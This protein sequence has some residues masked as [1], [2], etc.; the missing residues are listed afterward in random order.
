MR[1][2]A[3]GMERMA[4]ALVLLAACNGD[5]SISLTRHDQL[6]K[7]C[8]PGDRQAWTLWIESDQCQDFSGRWESFSELWV[9]PDF[10][11]RA[12]LIVVWEDGSTGRG[13]AC[14]AIFP[15]D[16]VTAT[17][18]S[19]QFDT[20]DDSAATG[21]VTLDLE[22]GTTYSQSFDADICPAVG[23]CWQ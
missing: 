19:V 11:P 8:G 20:V 3:W 13:D 7:T 4:L 15:D 10:P 1:S 23:E 2:Y 21:T 9:T 16:C 12:G 22:D 5:Q 17:G 18:G 14:G 6:G